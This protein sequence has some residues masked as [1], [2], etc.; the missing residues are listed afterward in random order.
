LGAEGA[1]LRQKSPGNR[2]R[3]YV[4]R[5][6]WFDMA[7]W[8]PGRH[9]GLP[10]AGVA[11]VLSCSSPV[12]VRRPGQPDLAGT[13]TVAGLTT[14]PVEI[15]HDGTQQGLQLEL[16]PR[17]ARVLLGVPAA[18]LADGVFSL[19][20]VVGRRAS[21]LTDRLAE[22]AGPGERAE[23]LETVLTRWLTEESRP[24]AVDAVWHRLVSSCGA[25]PISVIAAE[26]GF[27]RR[28]LSQLVGAELG[29]T[30]KTAARILRFDHAR[31][32]ISSGRRSSLAQVAAA[33]GY[34][35]QAH[36]CHD[37]KR[38]AGCTPQEWIKEELPF[39]QDNV[40][41]ADPS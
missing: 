36:L 30:P 7:G 14:S 25:A 32:C 22:T 34:F 13:A 5:C 27:G 18:V 31:M 40:A 26:V 35:D 20:E 19:E 41:R 38:F 11:L 12:V 15:L 4:S 17:G 39:L 1:T 29:I 28:H 6:S 16:T 33:C 2:L 24:R 10:G 21:E 8:P 3:P 23:A 9:R 37:W